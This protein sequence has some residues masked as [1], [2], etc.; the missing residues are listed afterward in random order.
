MSPNLPDVVAGG[1]VAGG[2]AALGADCD[3]LLRALDRLEE[4]PRVFHGVRSGLLHVGVAAGLDGLDPMPR[5][6]E[7]GSGDQHGV[8]VIACVQL[9]VV[10]HLVDLASGQLLDHSRCLFPSQTPDVR[11]CY[12]L[13]VHGLLVRYKG[14][15]IAA[16]HA[17]AAADDARAHAVVGAGNPG[18]AASGLGGGDGEGRCA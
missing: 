4:V 16:Q 18:V 17:V 15:H 6:L 8:D 9:V 14:G 11:D 13:E 7:V 12:Q 2:G 3:D 10:A 5:M 1:L